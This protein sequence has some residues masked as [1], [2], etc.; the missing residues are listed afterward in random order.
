MTTVQNQVKKKGKGNV[1]RLKERIRKPRSKEHSICSK[2]QKDSHS[3]P[4]VADQVEPSRVVISVVPVAVQTVARTIVRV[5]TGLR[6]HRVKQKKSIKKKFR[7][8][9]GKLR[10]NLQVP[11]DVVKVLKQNIAGQNVMNKPKQQADDM[12]D[13]K[14]QLT[15]FISVS[16]LANLMDVSYCRGYR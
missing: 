8:K 1:F 7:I 6:S 9:S 4:V 2:N 5:A 10:P 11:V 15:E 13:N 12:Q 16:E 3:V 14:L